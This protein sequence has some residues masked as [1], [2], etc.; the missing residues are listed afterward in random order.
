MIG[1]PDVKVRYVDLDLFR[2]LRRKAFHLDRSQMLV[3]NTVI[4]LAL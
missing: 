1:I 3:D 2:N 4:R